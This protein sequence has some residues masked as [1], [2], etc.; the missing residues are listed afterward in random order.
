MKRKTVTVPRERSSVQSQKIVGYQAGEACER[1]ARSKR[2]AL[3]FERFLLRTP[4]RYPM[5]T[6]YDECIEA[7][8]EC[9]DT[10]E[11]CATACLAENDVKMMADCIRLDR[12]C[13]D[14]CRLAATLMSRQSRFAR[15]FCDLCAAICE[16]CGKECERHQA[17]HCRRCAAACR[18]CAE[19]CRRMAAS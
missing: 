10:C 5:S 18:A 8:N 7:C 15:Q 4:R 19:Q 9:A 16:A 14:A 1:R 2:V 13:A 6:S 17:D 3:A 11:K 12:D